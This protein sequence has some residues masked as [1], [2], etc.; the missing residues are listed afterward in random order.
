MRAKDMK[1][2]WFATIYA[3]RYFDVKYAILAASVCIVFATHFASLT[4]SPCDDLSV[5]EC[6]FS[7]TI[8][9]HD[10]LGSDV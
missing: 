4:G 9:F 10:L 2:S 3:L 7:V 5:I 1:R 6:S 8:A